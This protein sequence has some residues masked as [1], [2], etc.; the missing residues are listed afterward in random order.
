MRSA[1]ET[2][3]VFDGPV[4][5][6]IRKVVVGG[7]ARAGLTIEPLD[8]TVDICRTTTRPSSREMTQR[9]LGIPGIDSRPSMWCS[10]LPARLRQAGSGDVIEIRATWQ[11]PV[12]QLSSLRPA[13]MPTTASLH[14]IDTFTG[15]PGHETNYLVDGSL[16]SI[17]AAFRENIDRAGFGASGEG[18][19]RSLPSGSQS[20]PP[21]WCR[22][23][24]R[25]RAVDL[26]RAWRQYF[27]K[28]D[29]Q[30]LDLSNYAD[31]SL[32]AR[33]PPV[34]DGTTTTLIYE[35]QMLLTEAVERMH[36][37]GLELSLVENLLPD[38]ERAGAPIQKTSTLSDC[39]RRVAESRTRERDQPHRIRA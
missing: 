6:Q 2:T 22:M 23:S 3:F 25:R 12:A 10:T 26:Q 34:C 13:T 35:G 1:V 18:A 4:R 37:T 36:V 38:F 39:A 29:V 15:N 20:W 19:T 5:R 33:G 30:E 16:S 14:A 9:L 11:R 27:I 8:D 17:E 7:L 32:T 28:I 21:K 24:T 31:A